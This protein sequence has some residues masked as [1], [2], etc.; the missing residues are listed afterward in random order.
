MDFLPWLCLSLT[1]SEGTELD[2]YHFLIEHIETH[3]CLTSLLNPSTCTEFHSQQSHFKSQK[4]KVWWNIWCSKKPIKKKKINPDNK[5]SLL[6]PRFQ[7]KLRG[8]CCFLSD[9]GSMRTLRRL[10]LSQSLRLSS[11]A[12][13]S[14]S[15]VRTRNP[16]PP[17]A[18]ITWS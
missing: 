4:S 1:T 6:C 12:L 3:H 9:E 17:K 16:R 18:V 7:I 15:T 10:G 8:T 13:C 11:K 5:T 14:S 2:L